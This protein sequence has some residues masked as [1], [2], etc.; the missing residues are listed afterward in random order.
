[1]RTKLTVPLVA[2]VM[3]SACTSGDRGDAGR[4]NDSLDVFYQQKVSWSDCGGFASRPELQELYEQQ[5]GIDCAKVEVPLDYADPGAKKIKL[6]LLRHRALDPGKR[7]GS[8]FV[9]P[10]GPGGSG[11]EAAAGLASA[12]AATELGQRFDFVGFDPRGVG[13]SEPTVRCESDTKRDQDRLVLHLDTSERGVQAA[14][15]D[16]RDELDAC[17]ANT[18]YGKTALANLGTR[19]VVKDL[20]IL[21]GALGDDKLTYLGYSYGTLIGS[22][23]ARAFPTKV[24]AMV[25]DGAVDKSA[26]HA[27][28]KIGQYRGFQEAFEA[29]A[30]ACAQ[31]GAC[32]LGADATADFQRLARPLLTNPLPVGDRKLSYTDAVTAVIAAL[33]S[34]QSWPALAQAI[35]QLRNGDGQDLLALADGYLGRDAAGRYNNSQLLLTAVNCLDYERQ[36]DRAELTRVARAASEAAPFLDPG[37]ESPAVPDICSAWPGPVTLT[38]D[39]AFK[40]VP[41]MMVVSVTGDPATPHENGVKLAQRL[42]ARLVTVEGEGHG[43]FLS[44]GRECV[45]NA[46]IEYLVDLKLPS[47]DVTCG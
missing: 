26:S 9:N 40:D 10:G 16:I 44:M 35:D 3:A 38:S 23:Y 20:D 12:V 42:G 39:T 7:I 21:R 17:I 24:R 29:F 1:M 13:Q 30:Q 5:Q 18:Q 28:M 11:V 15:K 31:Q 34:E 4:K 25:L 27:D 37:L 2:L 36:T 47:A 19:E 32:P 46:A 22:E 41:T 43:A 6:A 45:D 14:E 33:Y 8:L